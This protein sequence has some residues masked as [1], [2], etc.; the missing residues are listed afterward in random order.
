M[1]RSGLAAL[2][3]PSM[4]RGWQGRRY[5]LPRHV[6]KYALSGCLP[7]LFWLWN[8]IHYTALH[9]TRNGFSLH[10]VSGECSPG[11]WPPLQQRKVIEDTV[12]LASSKIPA[13]PTCPP[14]GS[15]KSHFICA[16]IVLLEEAC[17]YFRSSVC[18]SLAC[19]TLPFLPILLPL[20]HSSSSLDW[21]H[22]PVLYLSQPTP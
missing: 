21:E 14:Y 3:Y 5:W 17:N 1:I 20:L 10:T 8:A 7:T 12:K 19:V 6:Y 11:L 15:G 18:S 16:N 9:L 13:A 2:L 22:Q 4:E